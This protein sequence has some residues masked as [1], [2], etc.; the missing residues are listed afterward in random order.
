MHY[1][2]TLRD[3]IEFEGIGL[4]TGL[5]ARVVVRPAGAA[6]GISFRIDGAVTIPARAEFV[7][8][9]RRATVL[10]SGEH[11]VST[12]EHLLS[13]LA[14]MAIDNA[15][16]EVEG[17]EIPAMDG[18]A[19]PFARAIDAVGVVRL[20][21]PR[22]RYA[23]A[24]PRYF[25]DAEKLLIVLPAGEFRVKVAVA[26]DPPI[27]AQF[28]EGELTPEL[29]LREIAASRTFA[30]AHEVE[31]LRAR[32]LARGGTLE[33]AVIF[34]ESGPLRPLR[35][36][37][38]PVRHKTLDLIGDL[39]LLGAWPQCEVVAIKGGHTLHHRAV[40]ELCGEVRPGASAAR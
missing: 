19:L 18:S 13:A 22:R 16:V 11:S 31:T 9:T 26:Y 8:D 4:H 14:G 38:E 39:A 35:Y 3:T 21:E 27:G 23:P 34:D 6:S 29:Y 33:N 17:P 24:A 37:D 25:R 20:S 7:T 28:F 12:V 2:T 32:G 36:D 10:G 30:F 1:Q 5:P 40:L 15:L